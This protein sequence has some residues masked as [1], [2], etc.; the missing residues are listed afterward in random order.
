MSNTHISRSVGKSRYWRRQPLTPV[1]RRALSL[2]AVLA[3]LLAFFSASTPLAYAAGT[4]NVST[5]NDIV[6]GNTSSIAALSWYYIVQ[7]LWAQS[8]VTTLASAGDGNLFFRIVRD[9]R[10]CPLRTSFLLRL[11]C[12]R[13]GLHPGTGYF[14]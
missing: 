8:G 6:D 10:H 2:V 9:S 13:T 5:T 12:T 14:R 7:R 1:G 4:I 3:L 11:L